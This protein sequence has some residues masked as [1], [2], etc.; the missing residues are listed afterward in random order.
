MSGNPRSKVFVHLGLPGGQSPKRWGLG[1]ERSTESDSGVPKTPAGP[2]PNGSP[3][4]LYVQAN[5]QPDCY[6]LPR[7]SFPHRALCASIGLASIGKSRRG[8]SEE[9]RVG[10]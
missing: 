4:V 3:E 1:S 7:G 2:F 9:R 10:K 5:C 6:F 8:R